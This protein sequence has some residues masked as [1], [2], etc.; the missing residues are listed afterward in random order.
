MVLL[1]FLSILCHIRTRHS[2]LW[3]LSCARHDKSSVS[4]KSCL[5]ALSS[6]LA[7]ILNCWEISSLILRLNHVHFV[8]L[9]YLFLKFLQSIVQ[10]TSSSHHL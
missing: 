4:A 1:Q 8:S 10:D 7:S 2:S 9:W 5:N 3:S 6:D